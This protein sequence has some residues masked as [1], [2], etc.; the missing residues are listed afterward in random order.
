MWH[1]RW[2]GIISVAG[3]RGLAASLL[4]LPE[5]HGAGGNVPSLDDV[6]AEGRYEQEVEELPVEEQLLF[7][8]GRENPYPGSGRLNT[9]T[10]A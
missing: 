2:S 4:S 7:G 8:D 5:V 1:R 10:H 6:L 3:Q 9:L